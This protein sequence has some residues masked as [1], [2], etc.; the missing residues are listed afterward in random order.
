MVNVSWSRK[1]LVLSLLASG[2]ALC[3]AFLQHD[4][5][6]R[7][8]AFEFTEE[9][10]LD[11]PEDAGSV[12]LWIPVPA[13][14]ANQ[15]TEVLEVD[16]PFSY[17]M[18]M[19]ED[20]DNRMLYMEK[21]SPFMNQ[22]VQIT[23]RYKIVRVAQNG[24]REAG[25]ESPEVKEYLEPRGL[26]V[27]NGKIRKIARRTTKGIKDPMAKARALYD[28]VQGHMSY[29]KTGEGWGR[30]DSVYACDVSKGN[31]TDFH[32]LFITL[33]RASGIPAR[34]QMGIP[35]PKEVSG[36]PSGYYHCWAEF[37][38]DGRGWFPVDI[39]EAWKDPKKSDYFF[40]NLDADRLLLSTGREIRL[41][42]AQNG[43]PLNY[44]SRPYIEID[45]KAFDGYLLKRSYKNIG[46][47][48]E[49]V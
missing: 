26:E 8:R 35:L 25:G 20:F 38:I 4:S 2:S 5:P 43:S 28:Y 21:E 37:Y 24:A 3:W 9:L 27:I 11:V 30:G 33:A 49:E 12:R 34:F 14:N 39:S 44:F 42:P 47:S 10:I 40:G 22:R 31:C 36:E 19:D 17:R 16:A 45:G 13:Q 7:E 41:S 23:I 15:S 6:D 1:L 32:S 48:A 18:M 29:D 46:G